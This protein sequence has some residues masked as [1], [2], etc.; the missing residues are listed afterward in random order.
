MSEEKKDK[1]YNVLVLTHE[2]I[3][4][5]VGIV[6][7]IELESIMES[8]TEEIREHVMNEVA[9]AL[10]EDKLPHDFGTQI[11]L[12]R[13]VMHKAYD[14]LDVAKRKAFQD[15]DHVKAWSVLNDKI[16]ALRE[17]FRNSDVC[18][19]HHAAVEVIYLERE[20]LDAGVFGNEKR[21]YEEARKNLQ[22]YEKTIQPKGPLKVTREVEPGI[23]VTRSIRS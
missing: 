7:P 21:V 1:V 22:D 3:E 10:E 23:S 9:N 12:L 13:E 11:Y 5:E 14:A 2:E 20:A 6:D 8:I 15:P 17:E 16:D 18:K 4:D 19:A